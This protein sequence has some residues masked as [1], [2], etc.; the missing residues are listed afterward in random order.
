MVRKL[1]GG[2][3]GEKKRKREKEKKRRRRRASVSGSEGSSVSS[4]RDGIVLLNSRRAP[5][6]DA[7]R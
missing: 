4:F 1:E 5:S 6:M 7:G 3:R 2:G